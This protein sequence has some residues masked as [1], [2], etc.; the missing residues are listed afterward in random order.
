MASVT[1]TLPSV[2]GSVQNQ[3]FE[4]NFAL[5]DRILLGSTL[6]AS[7]NDVFFS[8]FRLPGTGSSLVHLSLETSQVSSG[9]RADLTS[10]FE[11]EGF[12]RLVA[13]DGTSVVMNAP[14]HEDSTTSLSD[15]SEPYVWRINNVV[16]VRSFTVNL[17]GLTDKTLVVTFDDNQN[18][19]PVVT[20]QADE[21]VVN[22]GGSVALSG[23]VTDPDPTP[24]TIALAL[25]ANPNIGTFSAIT[26]NGNAWTATWDAPTTP[27]D[28]DRNVV[29]TIT[30]T[31][32][33]ENLTGTDQVNVTVRG[34][35]APIV[36]YE[37]SGDQAVDVGDS[38]T[39]TATATDPEGQPMTYSHVSDIGGS[40]AN[41][42]ALVATWVAPAVTESTV[43]TFTFTADDG[44][45]TTSRTV[46]RIIRA[47]ATQPLALPAVNDQSFATGDIVNL[48]LPEADEGLA[49]YIYSASGLPRGLAFRNRA[50]VGRPDLPGTY[51]VTYTVTDSNQDMESRMFDIAITGMAIPQ[52][53][54]LNMRMDWGGQFY[55][56]P[57]SNVTGR[58]TSDIDW[59]RGKG[60]SIAV[61]SRV[62]AGQMQFELNSADGLFNEKNTDS[63]LFGL[64]RPGIQV[65]LRNGVTPLFTG[66][67]I[68]SPTALRQNGQHRTQVT[69]WGI[70]STAFEADVSGGSLTAEST[71]Q[72]FIELCAKADVPYES[73]QPE[74]GDAYVMGRWWLISKL[75]EALGVLERTEG[76]DAFEDRE[77]ELGFHLGNY[78]A[79]QAVAKTFVQ[80][81]AG[82]G[83]I[84]IVGEPDDEIR[85]KDIFNE[86]VGEVR[87]FEEKADETV[88]A[89]HDA[90][91]IALGGR[92]DLVSV[93]PIDEGA[94]TEL[95]DPVRGTDWRAR[96]NADG[97][98]T[99]RDARVE[100]DVELM[101]FNETH[102]TIVYPN[103]TGYDA[104]LYVTGLTVKGTV[105]TEGTPLQVLREDTVSK[106]RYRPKTRG[107]RQTWIRSVTDMEVRADA[108]LEEL[109][110]PERRVKLDTYI[111]DWNEF[112]ALDFSDRVAIRMDTLESDGFIEA[113]RV[114]IPL[115]GVLPRVT[116]DIS[117]T[118]T[119]R[120]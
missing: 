92:L 113:E 81:A 61:L 45:R 117:L 2:A 29:L 107:L 32:P 71:A 53:T 84:T 23:T 15:S 110:T 27:T 98:G 94:V 103:V 99:N 41:P 46:T 24:D 26:V 109:A 104:T 100:V 74:P 82:P 86:I 72:A 101:D 6:S 114:R 76:G 108:Q 49:P 51:T 36:T 7:G 58:I 22:A 31:E 79:E 20:I 43:A 5:N 91:P 16:D 69:A 54:G 60:T 67:L 65:Q 59:E 38:V 47:P 78:R 12:I 89:S 115:S 119:E 55:A 73:P 4:Y 39:L 42:T 83:E 37:A 62:Q 1:S 63:P 48:E 116:Y 30:G 44:S 118:E 56:N 8:F 52:P 106:Q 120:P 105:L 57:H 11:D 13:S 34:N 21:S 96:P 10:T 90:I 111:T 9:V 68:D 87:Q 102:I 75:W 40:I 33:D 14:N 85:T 28:N 19:P 35:R 112:A 18:N 77:G 66:V 88:F 70:I 25:S 17:A 95:T 97:T 93:Y 3:D 50:I 64:I 80:G